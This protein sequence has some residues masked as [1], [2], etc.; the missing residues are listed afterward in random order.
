MFSDTDIPFTGTQRGSVTLTKLIED[1]SGQTNEMAGTFEAQFTGAY[2]NRQVMRGT[3]TIRGRF[4]GK[5]LTSTG[6]EYGFGCGSGA[7]RWFG[8]ALVDSR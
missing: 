2:I 1:P 6:S 3:L 7:F 8:R 5:E 4:E